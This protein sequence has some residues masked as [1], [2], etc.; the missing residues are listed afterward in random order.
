MHKSK[1]SLKSNLPGSL[2]IFSRAWSDDVITGVTNHREIILNALKMTRLCGKKI[3]PNK[4]Q[5]DQL[6]SPF[7]IWLCLTRTGNY[8]IHEFDWLK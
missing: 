8:Q 5:K 7:I 2:C 4:A 3:F 1:I 6:I